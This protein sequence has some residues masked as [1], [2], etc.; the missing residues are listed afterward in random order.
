MRLH[1]IALSTLLVTPLSGP[2][3]AQGGG[4]SGAVEDATSGPSAGEKSRRQ[5]GGS[6]QKDGM[7]KSGSMQK[8]SPGSGP[9]AGDTNGSLSAPTGR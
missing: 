1:V 5:R 9:S 8:E 3:F 2:G 7:E 4:P 6:M